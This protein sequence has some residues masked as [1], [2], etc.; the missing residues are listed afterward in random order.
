MS[1]PEKP[2]NRIFL[3]PGPVTS[4]VDGDRHYVDA[5]ALSYLYSVPLKAC[6]V[7]LS[8]LPAW[9]IQRMRRQDS[10]FEHFL[11]VGVF[12]QEGDVHLYPRYDGKYFPIVENLP[13]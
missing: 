9:W 8:D 7:V 10:G 12:P 3:H 1:N 13:A 11:P 4:K 2:R 5:A 6:N